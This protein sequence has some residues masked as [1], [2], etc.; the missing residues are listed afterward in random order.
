MAY[1]ILHQDFPH[2]IRVAVGGVVHAAQAKSEDIEVALEVCK[3]GQVEGVRFGGHDTAIHRVKFACSHDLIKGSHYVS[4]D[5]SGG[6]K[7]KGKGH[8]V[9]TLCKDAVLLSNDTPITCK[10]CLANMGDEDHVK[11]YTH[12]WVI[13]DSDGFFLKA[14]TWSKHSRT[15]EPAD[16]KLYRVK[17]ATSFINSYTVFLGPRG[18]EITREEYYNANYRTRLEEGY[19]KVRRMGN[20]YKIRKVIVTLADNDNDE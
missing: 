18:E 13:Q 6:P 10:N 11:K 3:K 12:R 1:C 8:Y 5:G 15:T 14:R 16:A 7:W 20:E 2:R 17:G 19:G 4:H 9:H